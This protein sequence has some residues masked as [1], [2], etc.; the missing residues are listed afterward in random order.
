MSSDQT[1]VAAA[2]EQITRLSTEIRSA[3]DHLVARHIPIESNLGLPELQFSSTVLGV[4]GSNDSILIARSPKA[5][6]DRALL[7]RPRCTFVAEPSGAHLEFVASRPREARLGAVEA[8]ELDFP[9]VLVHLRRRDSARVEL[10]TPRIW[11][12]VMADASGFLAFEGYLADVSDSGV[13]LV[14]SSEIA[15]EPGTLLRGCRAELP[16]GDSVTF[17]VEVQYSQQVE[18]PEALR[19]ERARANRSGCRF[20]GAPNRRIVERLLLAGRPGEEA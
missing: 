13:A 9:E 7:S 18:I 15:L 8:I 2:S 11:V 4:G 3:I 12:R 1:S 10:G 20:V 17:D 14:Y 16:R 19:P 6:S 5:A